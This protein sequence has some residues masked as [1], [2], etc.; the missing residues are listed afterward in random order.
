MRMWTARPDTLCRAH[1]LGEHGEIHKFLAMCRIA[2]IELNRRAYR[3]AETLIKSGMIDTEP[4]AAKERHDLL[5]KELLAR[6]YNHNSPFNIEQWTEDVF[7]VFGFHQV[8]ALKAERDL[9]HRCPECA[10][11]HAYVRFEY[12]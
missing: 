3:H 4:N 5:A 12:A 2:D 7:N 8:D 11:R 6:G 1:L 10:E 9:I